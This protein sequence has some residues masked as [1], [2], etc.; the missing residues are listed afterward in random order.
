MHPSLSYIKLATPARLARLASGLVLSSV[1]LACVT[2]PTVGSAPSETPPRLVN[3]P[4][5]A[6]KRVWNN[7]SAFGPVP[8]NLAAKGQATCDALNTQD[9]KYKA[10]GYHPRAQNYQG[11]AMTEGGYYCVPR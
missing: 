8:A 6:K 9:T 11:Q 4:A 7:P 2:Y 10:I 5:D 3:D 1:L